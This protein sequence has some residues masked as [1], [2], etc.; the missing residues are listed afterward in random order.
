M[1]PDFHRDDSEVRKDG[2]SGFVFRNQD[3]LNLV[4]L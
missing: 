4:M 3:F 1:D 2:L